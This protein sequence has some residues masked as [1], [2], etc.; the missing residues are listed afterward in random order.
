MKGNWKFFNSS[1]F[2]KVV[3]SHAPPE[4]FNSF[5]LF[6]SLQAFTYYSEESEAK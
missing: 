2:L 6:P 1:Q 5:F 3:L 4:L